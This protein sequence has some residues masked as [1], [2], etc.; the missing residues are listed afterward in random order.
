MDGLGL[1]LELSRDC[2]AAL[3]PSWGRLGAVLGRPGPPWGC[4]G[5]DPEDQGR[6]KAVLIQ[7]WEPFL[8]FFEAILGSFRE[9]F[10][11]P[12]FGYLLDNSGNH[13]GNHFEDRIVP[14]GAKMS[15]KWL[16]RTLK[17]GRRGFAKN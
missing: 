1:V 14:A 2:L 16:S 12:V 7:F 10:F 15:P 9:P 4:L 6:L 8:D 17:A 13:F 11:G 5:R 3:G